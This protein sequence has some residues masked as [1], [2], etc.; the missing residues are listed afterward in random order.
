[1]IVPLELKV[2]CWFVWPLQ[3]QTIALVPLVVPLPLASR[4][5]VLPPTVTVSAFDEVCV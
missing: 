3:D 1:V 4:H 5:S 2:H